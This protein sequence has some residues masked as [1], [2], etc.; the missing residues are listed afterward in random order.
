MTKRSIRTSLR[1][2]A[3]ITAK[4][5]GDAIRNRTAL[6]IIL[7]SMMLMLSSMALPLLLRLRS[8]PTAII[9]DPGRSPLIRAL[10]A[11]EEFRVGIADSPEEL[12]EIVGSSAEL[13]LGLIIPAGFG[14]AEEGSDTTPL[15]LEGILPHWAN[16][17]KGSELAAFFEA[18]LEEASW[19]DI[20]IE[21]TER[22]AY[23]QA[24]TFGQHTMMTSS[25]SMIV[26]TI[27][28]ALVP[29]L[30]VEEKESHTL[31]A[32]L[33][34]PAGYGQVVLGKALTGLFYC[35]CASLVVYAFSARW[36][37]HGWL[38]LLVLGL[39]AA[40]AVALGLLMGTL[41]DNPASANMGVGL[42]LMVMLL[43][44]LLGSIIGERGP[45][46]LRALL[47][48]IPSGAFGEALTLTTLRTAQPS[49]WLAPVARLAGS[50]IILIGLIAWRVHRTQR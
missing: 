44:A 36:F 5:I 12:E 17:Q 15:V 13:R 21:I 14:Q 45:K 11:R 19:Q 6:S 10:T 33:V 38:L 40:L 28:L 3:S 39:G 26:L 48:W 50:I 41:I 9:Y 24:G 23:P 20:S 32:L 29:L 30:L 31:D 49:D 16:D 25:M 37:V 22:R 34:S 18:Q 42:V 43:P 8:A 35:A 46:F 27:G 2:V 4:D 47:L 7:G 1:I